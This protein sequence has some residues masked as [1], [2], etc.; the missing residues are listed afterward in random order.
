MK[1]LRKRLTYANVMSSIAVFLVLGGGAAFAANQ[2][3]KNSVGSKQLKKN[4]VTA[5]KIKNNAV[6][7]PKIADG[8][9]TGGKLA[10]GSVTTDKIGGGAVTTDR[11]AEGA[12]AGGKI[13]GGAVTGDKI[14]NGTVTGEKL[15]T[16][17]LPSSTLG[18]PVAG[19]SVSSGGTVRAWFN[20][21]G[22]KPTAEK[23]GT[24]N[25]KL[26]FPGL[27]GQ[28]YYDDSIAFVSLRETNPGEITRTSGNGNPRINTYNS[29]GTAADRS[30]EFVLFLPGEE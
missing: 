14:A 18:L 20:R 28:A 23:I 10:N 6:T 16:E 29:G 26:V 12:V 9:V 15:A 13:A 30:F 24:G 2:L 27:E 4:A 11:I 22:G 3:G 25:Y 17:Y 5:V 19:A 8:A 1:Q 21:F 7:N